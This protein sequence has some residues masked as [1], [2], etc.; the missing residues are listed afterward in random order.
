MFMQ[1]KL[2][3]ILVER[4]VNRSELAKNSKMSLVSCV[5]LGMGVNVSTDVLVKKCEELKC[6]IAD[7]CEIIPDYAIDDKVG[8]LNAF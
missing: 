8:N 7:I 5:K 1:K 6:S 2:F 4:G 3:E